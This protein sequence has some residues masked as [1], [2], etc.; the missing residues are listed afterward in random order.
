M[1]LKQEFIL[2]YH[3]CDLKD[4]DV[5]YQNCGNC[6]RVGDCFVL[7]K[8]NC[9]G[10]QTFDDMVTHGGYISENDFWETNGI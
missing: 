10:Q 3:D 8:L 2:R 5:N 9:N 1:Q 7:A 4:T 6:Y